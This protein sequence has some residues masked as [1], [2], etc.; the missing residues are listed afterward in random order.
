MKKMLKENKTLLILMIVALTCIII[1]AILL[2]KYFYF[3]NG[4]TKYGDRL[5][6]IEKIEIKTDKQNEVATKI[7][8]NTNDED[9]SINITRKIVYIRI[10]FSEKASLVDAQSVAVKSLENFSDEEKEYYDFEYTLKQNTT[11]SS[12]GFLIMG[13]K[14][15]NGTNLVWNNNNPVTSKNESE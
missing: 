12:D 13:A 3:G 4:Q 10:I 9:A 8:E 11:E 15:V 1:S 7:K 2:F 14:N 5:N 6:G